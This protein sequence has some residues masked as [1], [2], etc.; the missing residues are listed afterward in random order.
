MSFSRHFLTFKIPSNGIRTFKTTSCSNQTNVIEKR[1]VPKT[2]S[3]VV[4]VVK[5]P[6]SSDI[7]TA[8]STKNQITV[9][10]IG[11]N[12]EISTLKSKPVSNFSEF[13]QLLPLKILEQLNQEFKGP[14]TIQAQ[15]STLTK[16]G[17]VLVYDFRGPIPFIDKASAP[18]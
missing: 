5:R 7:I 9:T 11:R 4:L 3:N 8:K 18:S 12:G 2:V 17:Y 1:F 14:T 16:I 10:K 6:F 15:E 13:H